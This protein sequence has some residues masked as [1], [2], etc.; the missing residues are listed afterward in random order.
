MYAQDRTRWYYLKIYWLFIY[1]TQ[2]RLCYRSFILVFKIYESVF[3]C[4]TEDAID[5]IFP[6]Q[7]EKERDDFK[8]KYMLYICQNDKTDNQE[9]PSAGAKDIDEQNLSLN[10]VQIDSLDAV[11]IESLDASEQPAS[12]NENS[13]QE[14]EVIACTENVAKLL[15]V[16]N[17]YTQSKYL[18]RKCY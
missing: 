14:I 15:T 1:R 6:P 12:S 5:K 18:L 2:L 9:N 11:Q 16:Q 10:A 4:L 7:K 8:S 3:N 17:S 13:L